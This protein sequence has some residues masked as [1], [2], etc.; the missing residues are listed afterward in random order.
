MTGRIKAA[1]CQF[2]YDARGAVAI[3]YGLIASLIGVA[4]IL[5]VTS[6]GDE[7]RRL[8]ELVVAEYQ[9]ATRP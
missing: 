2:A 6:V 8:F 9:N 7:V 1:A 3:E 5:A 4:I